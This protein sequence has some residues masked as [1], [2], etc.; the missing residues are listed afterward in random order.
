MKET[1]C[2]SSANLFVSNPSL[3]QIG[4]NRGNPVVLRR[5]ESV[6][7]RRNIQIVEQLLCDFDMDQTIEKYSSQSVVE[8]KLDP[9]KCS[10][11]T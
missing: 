5:Q 10:Y 3:D 4:S 6:I 1:Q 9:S 7:R 2:S 8:L 11:D